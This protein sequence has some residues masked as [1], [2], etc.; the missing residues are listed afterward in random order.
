MVEEAKL[1]LLAVMSVFLTPTTN[2]PDPK[3]L[4]DAVVCSSLFD[5][6]GRTGELA[7]LR[8]ASEAQTFGDLTEYIAMCGLSDREVVALSK[9]IKTRMDTVMA[10]FERVF[11]S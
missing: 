3:R 6:P 9:D 7:R 4:I 5:E 10:D 8:R 1:E 11:R 2:P